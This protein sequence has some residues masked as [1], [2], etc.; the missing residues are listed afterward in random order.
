MTDL[1][2]L[3]R[4]AQPFVAFAGLLRRHGF[5]VAPDQTQTFI[6][7]VGLLGPRHMRDIYE[8]ALAT[9]A[10][11]PERRTEFEA[12]FRLMFLG[13]SLGAP[14][15]GEPDDEDEIEAF[16]ERDGAMEP[17]EA[18][19]EREVGAEA[20][21]LEA[22]ALRHFAAGNEVA[23][24]NAFARRAAGALPR[25][26]SYRRRASHSGNRWNIRRL[27]RDAVKRD[28]EVLTL[29]MLDR[30]SRQ[31][32]ILVMLDISGSM[33]AQ[34]D[35]GLRFCHAL[36]RAAERIE[37]FTIG[38]RLT[39]VTRAVRHR[40]RDQALAL[41]N[42]LVAD[43]DGGTRLGDALGAFLAVPRFAS[44]ARGSVVLILSDGLERGDVS[45]L[46]DAVLAL[47]RLAWRIVWLTPLAADVGY[48]PQTAGLKA[49]LPYIDHLGDGSRIER[50]C[51]E[52]LGLARSTA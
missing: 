2:A 15:A 26:R 23:A 4:G 7:A 52:V 31:R 51:D 40:Q 8:A 17:P 39:R 35:A 1:A 16:D 21:A 41:T 3:P 29:P 28:G 22:L 37:V 9:L 12:L 11:P 44:F 45:A 18:A 43:W 19:E 5:A 38:T 50:L 20:T 13:Q 47:S 36:A 24:L 46:A 48:R 25:Q 6:Q 49:I 42:T 32:R 14:A 27:L 34:T 33:K 30:K 10:P